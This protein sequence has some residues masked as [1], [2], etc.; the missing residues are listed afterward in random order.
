[1]TTALADWKSGVVAALVSAVIGGL[2]AADLWPGDPI[3][4]AASAF[5]AAT[6]GAIAA[7]DMRR[8]RVPDAW[9]LPAALGG[10][11]AVALEARSIGSTPLMML[12]HAMVSLIVCGGAFYLLREIYFRWRGVEGLGFGDVKLA[13]TGGI[14]L[15]WEIFPAVVT[16]AAVGAILWVIGAAALKRGWP[17][18]RKIPFG[19]FLAPAIWIC[20]VL[21]RLSG[22]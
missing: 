2:A 20:W 11:I 8:M 17:K 14:W 21:S 12:G 10:F 22:F 13:A 4:I 5:L 18:E 9:S 3:R 19:A 16:I 6:M 7:E 15:G 1:L